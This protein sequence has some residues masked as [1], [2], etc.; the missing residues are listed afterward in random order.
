MKIFP[1]S[2]CVYLVLDSKDDRV[3]MIDMPENVSQ[4]TRRGT[5]IS[6]GKEVTEWKVGDRVIK[7]F[8]AGSYIHMNAYGYRTETHVI[9]GEDEIQVRIENEDVYKPEVDI[10][11]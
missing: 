11:K 10:G 6:V 3:G 4:Q 1:K 2:R 5:I 9:C 7:P 8:Y